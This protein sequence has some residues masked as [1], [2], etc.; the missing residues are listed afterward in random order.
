MPQ[1]SDLR[2]HANTSTG[3]S[4]PL[5]QLAAGVNP[6]DRR[7]GKINASGADSSGMLV[8]HQHV[9]PNGEEAT[10]SNRSEDHSE[11]IM[12]NGIVRG[13][14][15]GAGASQLSSSPS[16]ISLSPMRY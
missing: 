6:V 11:G 12:T 8:V 5:H 15:G 2:N 13:T 3:G 1:T 10:V 16:T 7:K 9:Y 4:S 14:V